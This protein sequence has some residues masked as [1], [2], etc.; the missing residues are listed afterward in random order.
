MKIIVMFL[1]LLAASTAMSARVELLPGGGV[2]TI[3]PDGSAVVLKNGQ[4]TYV[5]NYLR[6]KAPPVRQ[7][8][9]GTV[10]HPDGSASFY[11]VDSDGRGYVLR[12]DGG[13]DILVP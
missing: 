8:R 11:E 5:E 1:F 4:Q 9:T 13:V 10:V 7:K 3:Y 2:V 6:P 12:P